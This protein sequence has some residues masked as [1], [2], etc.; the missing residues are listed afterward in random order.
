MNRTFH[1]ARQP[2]CPPACP[3]EDADRQRHAGDVLEPPGGVIK[4]AAFRS[5]TGAVP[6]LLQPRNSQGGPLAM[7]DEEK[8]RK[9]RFCALANR[10]FS[11]GSLD[12]VRSRCAALPGALRRFG[13]Y[14]GAV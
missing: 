7:S 2:A 8:G 1:A 13:L 5:G 11:P 14:C 12:Q 3:H 10:N 4:S 6:R 9:Q